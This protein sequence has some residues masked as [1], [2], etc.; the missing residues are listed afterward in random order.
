MR[1][2]EG[3]GVQGFGEGDVLVG[4]TGGGVNQEVVRGRPEDGG[5]ELAHHGCFFGAAPYYC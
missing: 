3:V 1:S 4:G 2:G 5:E